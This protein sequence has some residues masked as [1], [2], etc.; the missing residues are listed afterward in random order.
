FQAIS[1]TALARC[2][3]PASPQRLRRAG[4]RHA[5][6]GEAGL[7]CACQLLPGVLVL[8]AFLGK[9]VQGGAVQAL[10]GGLDG[11]AVF[12]HG[13]GH[14]PKRSDDDGKRFHVFAP[15]IGLITLKKTPVGVTGAAA[16]RRSGS[17][18][19]RSPADTAPAT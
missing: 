6:L 19:R 16:A 5:L 8:A 18:C 13:G 17:L 15:W 7:G 3:V 11:A 9:A 1:Q 10:A 4:V 2:D 12:R 14:D